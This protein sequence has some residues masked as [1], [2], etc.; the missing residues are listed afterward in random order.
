VP[1]AIAM[2]VTGH[3]TRSV[4]DRHDITGEEDLAEASHKL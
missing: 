2:K 3:L 1:K 4:F